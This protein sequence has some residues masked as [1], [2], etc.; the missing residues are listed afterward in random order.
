MSEEAF[1]V[2]NEAGHRAFVSDAHFKNIESDGWRVWT[3]EDRRAEQRRRTAEPTPR[4]RKTTAAQA[5]PVGDADSPAVE[6]TPEHEEQ[7]Q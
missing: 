1:E 5:E 2:V 6:A 4:A 7:V 3:D